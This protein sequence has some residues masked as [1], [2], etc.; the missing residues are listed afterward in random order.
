M[1]N[2]LETENLRLIVAIIS[3]GFAVW[4]YLKKRRIEKLLTLEAIQLHKNISVAL[5][6]T[7]AAIIT[8]SQGQ[9][10][11]SQIGRAQGVCQA[12]LSES[13]KLYCNLKDTT[14]DDIDDLIK[15]KQL[16]EQYRELYYSFSNPK[17]GCVGIYFKKV[18]SFFN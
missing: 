11:I 16:A 15:N 3:F 5:G 7:D 14:I 17:R 8:S 2:L 6:A 18:K 13:A 10:P 12:I 4:Q 1:N 9:D